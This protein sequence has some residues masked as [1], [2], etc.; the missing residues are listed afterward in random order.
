VNNFFEVISQ[1]ENSK[2][3]V[4]VLKTEHG[5]LETPAFI[6]CGTK[7]TVKG[8]LPSSLIETNTQIIL[9]NTYH[10]MLQPGSEV[11]ANSGGLQKFTN[12]NGPMMTDSGGYQIF[13]LGHGSVSEEIKGKNL[14]GRNKSLLKITEE[15][16]S[17]KNYLNGDKILLTPEKS[18]DIQ[19]D[20]GAD[21]IFVLDECTP[22]NVDKNYTK[23]SMHMTHRWAKRC[24]ENFKSD[25]KKYVAENGSAGKQKLYGIIQGGVYGDLRKQA[26][27]EICSMNFDGLAIGGSLGGTKEQMY[28]VFD[29]CSSS[30]DSSRPVHVLGIG[31][32]D[33]ILEGVSRGFD[34][35]DCVSPTRIARH[36]VML[37]KN[38]KKG[39]NLNN[40]SFK[41]DHSPLDE[42]SEIN[43][44]RNYSKAYIH[45]LF[46]SNEILGMTILSIYNIWFMNNF[47]MQIRKSIHEKRFNIFKSVMLSNFN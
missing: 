13:S 25:N 46:K 47:L 22:Y 21:L 2:A 38:K 31:G 26:C 15:G 14:T 40:S 8:V 11:I 34:T 27:E 44:G 37:S 9:S 45:H 39:I 1:D 7:A 19:R 43:I 5:N 3:R 4:G 36:G 29:F 28:E 24:M 10:L 20:L 6:F 17:F 16:A 18:I 12:W 23:K 33:D 42:N 35:F 41:N 30:I 32:L